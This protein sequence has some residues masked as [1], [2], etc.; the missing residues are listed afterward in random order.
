[1]STRDP[2]LLEYRGAATAPHDSD[3]AHESAD[4]REIFGWLFVSLVAVPGVFVLVLA[5]GSVLR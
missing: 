5:I 1:M 2:I 3:L 4:A